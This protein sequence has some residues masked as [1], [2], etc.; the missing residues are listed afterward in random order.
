MSDKAVVEAGPPA[1]DKSLLRPYR[2]GDAA[3]LYR[4]Y[5]HRLRAL[6]AKHHG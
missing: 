1:T 3:A 5:A 6:V 2:P 4:Q